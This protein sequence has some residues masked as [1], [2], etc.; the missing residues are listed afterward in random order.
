MRWS[1]G[2]LTEGGWVSF[3]GGVLSLRCIFPIQVGMASMQEEFR[4]KVQ[5]EK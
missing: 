4:G 2:R 3:L 1:R 5:A